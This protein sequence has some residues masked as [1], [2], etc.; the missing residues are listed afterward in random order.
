MLSLAL[1]A[2]GVIALVEIV[3][4]AGDSHDVIVSYQRWWRSVLAGH[5]NTGWVTIAGLLC[6][7][8]GALLLALQLTRRHRRELALRERRP[9]VSVTVERRALERSLRGVVDEVDGVGRARIR[10]RGARAA[11]GVHADELAEPDLEQR[12]TTAAQERLDT[13]EL[14]DPLRLTVHVSA[15]GAR[16]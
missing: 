13:L 10:V 8:A 7:A 3:A 14:A 15:K 2:G 6:C 12:V 5:W 4:S 16:A 9:G 1:I 11:V